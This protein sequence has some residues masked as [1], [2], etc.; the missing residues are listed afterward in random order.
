M[1]CYLNFVVVAGRLRL[2]QLG[3]DEIG[4]E[5]WPD[6]WRPRRNR[7]ERLRPLR[8]ASRA[9][10]WS[11]SS[12]D[13][14]GFRYFALVVGA[15][16]EQQLLEQRLSFV[17][18]GLGRF[19]WAVSP[20]RMMTRMKRMRRMKRTRLTRSQPNRLIHCWEFGSIDDPFLCNHHST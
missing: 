11:L 16:C 20:T 6:Y 17:A 12:R 18:M 1:V 13:P 15:K 14:L 8:L 5:N 3:S 10:G 19:E 2:R 9:I 4:L 7:I